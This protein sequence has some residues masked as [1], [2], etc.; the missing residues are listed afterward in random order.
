[1]LP[2]PTMRVCPGRHSQTVVPRLRTYTRLAESTLEPTGPVRVRFAPSPTGMLH[3]GGL[4]TALFNYLLSRRYGGSFILRIE[5]TDQKRLVPGATENIVRALEWAGLSFDEGPGKKGTTKY[6][7]SQ[8]GDIYFQ[9]AHELLRK[10]SAYRCF[11][12]SD[13]LNSLR[14]N[15]NAQGRTQMYDRHCLHLSQRQI[16]EK[17]RTGEP[18][19]IRMRSPNPA[20]PQAAE[21]SRF[22]D[23]VYGTMHFRGPAGFDDAVLLKSDGLPTYHLA[24]VVDDHLMGITHVLRG[25]EWLMSTPKHRILFKAFGW[26]IPQYA[27][28]PLL[29]NSDGSKL[30]KRNKDGPM[31]G[32]I[33]GG[34]LPSAVI[35]YVALLGWHPG[36]SDEL[37]ALDDLERL[38]SLGGLSRSKSIVSR[39]KLDW[40]NRQHLRREINDP[41]RLPIIAAQTHRALVMQT[42]TLDQENLSTGT[43]ER[44][45]RLCSDRLLFA[46]DI[47]D[48]APF[49]FDDPDLHSQAALKLLQKVPEEIQVPIL[50]A[51]KNTLDKYRNIREDHGSD[52][53]AEQKWA[54]FASDVADVVVAASPKQVMMMLRFALTGRPSGPR[55]PGLLAFFSTDTILR[56]LQNAVKA[57]ETTQDDDST[58]HI[59]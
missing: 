10:G 41:S 28:L 43:V 56:R 25:E 57:I 5:D 49:L 59:C 27:H 7:Q 24:N 48:V 21:V 35:N 29:M 8:R 15:A 33:D 6:F 36:G 53:M 18:Y 9:H 1:M 39:D 45:L 3:L 13:R 52:E 54:G 16:D 46:N 23:I 17:M 55:I 38:F 31:Q 12:S 42:T 22:N 51:A 4:R 58:Q 37:F 47:H 26:P 11:C 19:T 40:L 44:A 30:S 50:V 14:D 34:Y 2:R 32:Y 20:D